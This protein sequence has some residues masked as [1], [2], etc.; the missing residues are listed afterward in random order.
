[1][2]EHVASTQNECSLNFI[3]IVQEISS[4]GFISTQKKKSFESYE[5]NCFEGPKSKIHYSESWGH[6]SFNVYRTT[7]HR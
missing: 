1:M 6:K 2:L 3:N 5:P 7:K 4:E